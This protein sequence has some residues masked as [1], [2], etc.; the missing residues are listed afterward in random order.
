MPEK[1]RS[2]WDSVFN[3]DF[4]DVRIHEGSPEPDKIGAT[5]FTQ[6]TDIHF[7]PG[8][9][10]P[11][12]R[13]G[14]ELLG[15]ELTH[16]VQQRSGRVTTQAKGGNINADPALEREADDLGARAAQGQQVS[17]QGVGG[18]I[19]RQKKKT[20]DS[21]GGSSLAISIVRLIMDD[22]VEAAAG[23]AAAAAARAGVEQK[24]AAKV[25]Q[26]ATETANAAAQNLIR[27]ATDAKTGTIFTTQHGD[28]SFTRA[29]E[30]TPE[31]E[32]E[33]MRD[34]FSQTSRNEITGI[35]REAMQREGLEAATIMSNRLARETAEDTAQTQLD[36]AER[37]VVDMMMGPARTRI[38]AVR[39]GVEGT[40]ASDAID[41]IIPEPSLAPSSLEEVPVQVRGQIAETLIAKA[42]EA[43]IA[44]PNFIKAAAKAAGRLKKTTLSSTEQA[45]SETMS[46]QEGDVRRT[47]I[48]E[49]QRA[50]RVAVD[51]IEQATESDDT[52]EAIQTVIGELTE[53]LK[54]HCSG[55]LNATRFHQWGRK[56]ELR[57]ALK[58]AAREVVNQEIDTHMPQG[59]ERQGRE[60][61]LTYHSTLAKR[62]AYGA[63]KQ[64]V[65]EFL[66]EVAQGIAGRAARDQE[67][68]LAARAVE[69][70]KAHSDPLVVLRAAKST[71][72]SHAKDQADVWVEQLYENLEAGNLT[73]E[74]SAQQ[75][76][77]TQADLGQ[78]VR[79]R[80]VAEHS[81]EAVDS[82]EGMGKIGKLLDKIVPDPGDGI[83]VKLGLKIPVATDPFGGFAGKLNL[84]IELNGKAG[85]GTEGFVTAGVPAIASNPRHLELELGYAIGMSLEAGDASTLGFDIS[86]TYNSF[87]R[88]GAD[89]TESAMAAFRYAVYR[90]TPVKAIAGAWYGNLKKGRGPQGVDYMLAEQH[91]AAVEEQHFMGEKNKRTFAQY[92]RGIGV[93]ASAAA[94][95][96]GA[97]LG[98][99]G[100]KG[101]V[102]GGFSRFQ[103]VTGET[104][105]DRPDSPQSQQEAL[106]RRKAMNKG[107]GHGV[108]TK[109]AL[110]FAVESEVNLGGLGLTLSGAFSGNDLKNWGIE[111]KAL[112]GGA[113]VNGLTMDMILTLATALY[114]LEHRLLSAAGDH[115][116]KKQEMQESGMSKAAIKDKLKS[117]LL[118]R[119]A[120]S[121]ATT[122]V[123]I[124]LSALGLAESQV[125]ASFQF[126]L[127]G[128]SWTDRFDII[129]NTKVATP[130][131]VPV[132][133]AEINK[134][135]RLITA[136]HQGL[137]RAAYRSP[138]VLAE[139]TE[140]D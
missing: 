132:F 12:S 94:N 128:G 70:V 55:K 84:I 97:T 29:T 51:E 124:A 49:G 38:S 129:A 114:D 30:E 88:A 122:G 23:Q 46:G 64:D 39:A 106:A 115:L 76:S 74:E 77:G 121:V 87:V 130:D 90:G 58:R 133:S 112:I 120:S 7:A 27:A 108:K 22:N 113:L 34:D 66:G 81:I 75:A 60:D 116:E 15:H 24:L 72:L 21:L 5:A 44:D 109:N 111:L 135:T 85:R 138:G 35:A 2:Q 100:A 69:A 65:G 32:T 53:P 125:A 52:H 56:R 110:S 40:V 104:L 50:A 61:L 20:G 89:S 41:L 127:S 80:E 6:K 96:D 105:Q 54:E 78:M 82:E 139:N 118:K 67:M 137:T 134:E 131:T 37:Q 4:S 45:V 11:S 140:T 107:K 36:D 13:S 9:Y 119:T 43:A 25:R 48:G 99:L 1:I 79:D 10:D 26:K 136:E 93:G 31:R 102:S 68:A 33:R 91:A 59:Q 117:R 103:V 95:V 92:G 98:K 18:G 71:L 16:V 14:K 47:A 17:V 42:V 123:T 8:K 63:I 3:T 19:Q 57:E 73:A 28:G 62:K 101:K 86:A 126:G 83:S